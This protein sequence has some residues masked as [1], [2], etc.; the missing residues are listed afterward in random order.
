MATARLRLWPGETIQ[1]VAS[2]WMSR[3]ERGVIKVVCRIARHP[4]LFHHPARAQISRNRERY[5]LSKTQL[6]KTKGEHRPC[7]LCGVPAAPI[8]R[9]QTPS[10]LNARSEV[11]FEARNSKPDES[12]KRRNIHNLDSPQPEPVLLKV[13]FDPCS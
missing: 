10:N 1:D 7:T 8:F 11:C 2:D 12:G 6:L 13:A 4:K 9:S 3:W 5:N